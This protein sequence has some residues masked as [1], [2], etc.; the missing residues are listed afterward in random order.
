[1]PHCAQASKKLGQAFAMIARAADARTMQDARSRRSAA[2]HMR[3]R[4][5]QRPPHTR[6]QGADGRAS[7]IVERAV[8]QRVN[9]KGCPL[10]NDFDDGDVPN[11]PLN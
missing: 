11:Q 10:V 1:M 2:K 5:G 9:G 8:A 7:L 3:P 4:T 6:Q